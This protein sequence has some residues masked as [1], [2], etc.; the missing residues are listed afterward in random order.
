MKSKF[1]IIISSCLL[2]LASCGPSPEQ[3]AALQKKIIDSITKATEKATTLK[4][5]T[6]NAIQDSIRNITNEIEILEV[7]ISN[8]EAELE[9]AKDRMGQ[10]KEWQFGRT[11][12]EREEQIR[13][14]T[15][16]IIDDQK[17]ISF[18]KKYK[19]KRENKLEDSKRE[20]KKYQ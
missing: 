6:K 5:E 14:Q 12:S 8:M 10:I 11:A 17:Q 18:L 9:V 1:L 19:K 20:L 13:S 2:A 7:E 15:I 3:K 16:E 4:I